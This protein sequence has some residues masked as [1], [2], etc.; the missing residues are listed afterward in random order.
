[1]NE[2]G[3]NKYIKLRDYYKQFNPN[4]F[5]DPG[6]CLLWSSPNETV[7]LGDTS[8]LQA[9]LN[10][11]ELL[12]HLVNTKTIKVNIN[13]TTNNKVKDKEDIADTRL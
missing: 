6:D 1:L 4:E 11:L 9:N 13:S 7:N 3:T 12:E 2:L 5:I 10:E 8:L